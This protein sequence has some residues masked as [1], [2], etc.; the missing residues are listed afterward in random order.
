MI[1]LSNEFVETASKGLRKKFFHR[2]IDIP[3]LKA[4]TKD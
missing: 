1:T 3:I 4:A 2:V